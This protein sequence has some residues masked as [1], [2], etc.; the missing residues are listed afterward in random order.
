MNH[1]KSST[2]YCSLL[3]EDLSRV[4]TLF[5]AQQVTYKAAPTQLVFG[6]SRE[7][8]ALYAKHDM[9][10]IVVAEDVV[11]SAVYCT[12]CGPIVRC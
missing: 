7:R 10:L 12:A 6:E 9:N 5:V 3:A 2:L 11:L 1:D 8:T 4:T